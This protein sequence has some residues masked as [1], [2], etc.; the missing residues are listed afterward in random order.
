MED[1]K[2]FTLDELKEFIVKQRFRSFA[3]SQI[4]KWVYQQGV[5]DFDLMTNVSKS[6]RAFLKTQFYFSRLNLL[7]RQTSCDGTEKFLFELK[8][9]SRI[10]T[11][12]IPEGNRQT[13]CVSTQVGCKFRCGF[14]VSGI[15]GFKRNLEVSEIINQYI[16]ANELIAP[17]HITNIVFMGIGEPLDNFENVVKSV[18]ILMEPKGIDFGPRRICVSTIGITPKIKKLAKLNLGIKLSLSLHSADKKIR[19]QLM[20]ATKKYPLDGLIREMRTFVRGGKFPV[21]F[22]YIMI[23][24][25]NSS[26]DDAEKFAKLVKNIH[27]KINLI[28]YNPSPFFKWQPPPE[29]EMKD[30]THI[31]KKHNVFFT[32]R[33]PCGQDISASCGQ[34][35]AEFKRTSENR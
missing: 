28:S 26:V 16:H 1:I 10:E 11:V 8:D 29:K 31:L 22:E 30:F 18:R 17:S 27:C 32:L 34:L 2:N 12:V 20:P 21:T 4:F 24:G 23:K 35:K 33:K 15:N 14:C 5:E 9:K 19:Q 3:A 25:I 6:A 13:L 7:E